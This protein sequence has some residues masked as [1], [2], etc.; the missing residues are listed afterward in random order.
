MNDITTGFLDIDDV[1]LEYQWIGQAEADKPTL[2]FLHEGLGSVAMW[3]DFPQQLCQETGLSGFIYSRRGYGKSDP[4]LLPRKTTYMHEEAIEVLPKV[5]GKAGIEKAI[6]IGH[7]DGGSISLV[8]AA[9]EREKRTAGLVL[10][11]PHVFNEDL[12]IESIRGAKGLYHS[13]DLKER[14]SKYHNDVDHVF[15]GWND[16][17]LDPEFEHWNIEEYLSDIT[18]PILHI[19][20]EQDQYG[21]MAQAR[22]IKTQCQ[23]TV[24]ITL[25]AECGHSPHFDQPEVT[26]ESILRFVQTSQLLN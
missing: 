9:T 21:T 6:L 17:W 7:S 11:A 23:A 8:F 5:L 12:C 4:A 3:K 2:V 13:T 22:A 19:Q 20:G 25:L 1:K 18:V 24:E 14:L 26:I 16:I 15:W 10:L